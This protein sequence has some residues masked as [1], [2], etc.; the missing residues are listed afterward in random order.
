MNKKI[1]TQI[2]IA[3]VILT[4]LIVS[5]LLLLFVQTER[6]EID[7]SEAVSLCQASSND[8]ID[9]KIKLAGEVLKF[10]LANNDEWIIDGL[11]KDQYAPEKVNRLVDTVLNLKST[12][13][14]TANGTFG[15]EKPS[16]EIQ[17]NKK[18]GKS[19]VLSVGDKQP[20]GNKYFVKNQETNKIWLV[21]E[22]TADV[23]MQPLR[24]YCEFNR[25]QVDI[26][27]VN[28]ISI[29]VNN[30]NVSIQK[31]TDPEKKTYNSKWKMIQP[32][33]AEAND[34]FIDSEIINNINSL[35][36]SVPIKAEPDLITVGL[37]ELGFVT[38]SGNCTDKFEVL[39]N[40]EEYI[41]R[42]HDE[43]YRIDNRYIKFLNTPLFNYFQKMQNIVPMDSVSDI[44][45]SLNNEE[46]HTF[47]VNNGKEFCI[48]D[49]NLD[50]KSAKDLYYNI[51]SMEVDGIYNDEPFGNHWMSM[52][53]NGFGI[54]IDVYKVNEMYSVYS[55]NG[56]KHFIIKNSTLNHIADVVKQTMNNK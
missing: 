43:F 22:P 48:D 5:I 26:N 54:S 47:Y 12:E 32:F 14:I 19:Y 11:Q 8:V 35:N 23:I 33:E 7:D 18:D 16:A 27:S 28:R 37:V 29:S 1:R 44:V 51:I 20:A 24:Y 30:Q 4:A 38:A 53:F 21:S 56:E 9:I 52:K 49:V 50:E 34:D 2:I 40:N 13:E 55:K 45:I 42:Y 10:S 25:F 31:R 3:S 41:I 6:G 15:F 36:L 17:I 39:F 46:V